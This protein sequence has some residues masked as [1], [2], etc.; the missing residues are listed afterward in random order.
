MKH[1]AFLLTVMAALLVSGG[2]TRAQQSVKY[3]TLCRSWKAGTVEL[4]MHFPMDTTVFLY[5]GPSKEDTIGF[6]KFRI[7]LNKTGAYTG[8]SPKGEAS[9]GTWELSKNESKLTIRKSTGKK[10]EY[11]ILRAYPNYMELGIKKLGT[12]TVFKM[13]P[14]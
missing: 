9:K 5:S 4:Q 8:I 12:R 10:V 13:V 6:S 11:D 2:A 3:K 1:F 7:T 14:E